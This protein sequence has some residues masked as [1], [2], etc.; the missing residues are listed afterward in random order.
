MWHYYVAGSDKKGLRY[1]AFFCGYEGP[2]PA[3]AQQILRSIV[4]EHVE[5][6]VTVHDE[7]KQ[8]RYEWCP[9]CVGVRIEQIASSKTRRHRAELGDLAVVV[10]GHE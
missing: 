4:D 5:Y 2:P 1:P 8:P 7:G 9:V 10:G 3:V 6:F